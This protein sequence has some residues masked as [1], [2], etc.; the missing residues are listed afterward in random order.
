MNSR[1]IT[2]LSKDPDELSPLT[3]SHFLIG[4]SVSATPAYIANE[5][6]T[7]VFLEKVEDRV[8]VLSPTTS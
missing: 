3:P 2:E 7:S 6:F 4:T 5:K 1:Q 8:F